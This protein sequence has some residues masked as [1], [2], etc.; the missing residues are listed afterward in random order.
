MP[1]AGTLS[2]DAVT[3]DLYCSL[4]THSADG[5]CE[6]EISDYPRSP[7]TQLRVQFSQALPDSQAT[8]GSL[9]LDLPS[10]SSIPFLGFLLVFS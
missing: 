2:K 8:P 4:A 6:I 1:D 7:V 9:C 3:F 10:M 5:K